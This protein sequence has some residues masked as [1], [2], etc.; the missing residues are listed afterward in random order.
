MKKQVIQF[1]KNLGLIGGLLLMLTENHQQEEQRRKDG[2]QSPV[3][4]RE[5]VH[6]RV[7]SWLEGR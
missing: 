5:K 6:P 3:A 7:G 4:L 2:R 1:L